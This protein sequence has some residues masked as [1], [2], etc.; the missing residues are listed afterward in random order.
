[1]KSFLTILLILCFSSLYSQ[2]LN[3]YGYTVGKNYDTYL[4]CITCNQWDNRSINNTNGVYGS[5]FSNTSIHNSNSEFGSKFSD[6]S[7][8]NQFATHPPMVVNEKGDF[9][10]YLTTNNSFINRTYKSELTD[11]ILY[12]QS[13]SDNKSNR[14]YD[15][16]VKEE[17]PEPVLY[18]PDLKFQSEIY[19]RV[20][21][22]LNNG[23]ILNQETNEWEK[24]EVILRKVANKKNEIERLELIYNNGMYSDPGYQTFLD[25]GTY[26]I[27]FYRQD[28]YTDDIY[29]GE[30]IIKN[31]MLNR[32][33][34]Y[35]NNQRIVLW[36]EDKKTQP[37][38]GVYFGVMVDSPIFRKTSLI[39]KGV[40][41]KMFFI[42]KN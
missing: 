32:I 29:Y 4:G 25:D 12:N 7:P 37:V 10:G 6:K 9:I 14:A 23:F 18:K 30:A 19:N 42:S 28:Y 17:F 5:K 39:K 16:Y 20:E 41:V 40:L 35:Y 21:G 26:K 31:S 13:G 2:V 1:M 15:N 38:I 36:P 22:L 34:Y 27:G 33:V 8:H 3:L 11:K 24:R